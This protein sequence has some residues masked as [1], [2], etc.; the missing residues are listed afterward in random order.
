MITKGKQKHEKNE[1]MLLTY[2]TKGMN[3]TFSSIS[4]YNKVNI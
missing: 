2:R 4:I 3:V 1:Q